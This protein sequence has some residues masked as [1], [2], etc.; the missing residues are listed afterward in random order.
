MDEDEFDSWSRLETR[1][2]PYNLYENVIN[3]LSTVI[4]S[5]EQLRYNYALQCPGSK[6]LG[7][8][9]VSPT[10][11]H[12]GVSCKISGTSRAV[13]GEVKLGGSK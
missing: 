3:S 9:L 1:V 2:S 12:L 6:M 13:F 7:Q 10:S 4:D 8:I 5:Q 11:P